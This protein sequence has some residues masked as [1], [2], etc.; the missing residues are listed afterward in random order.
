MCLATAEQRAAARAACL[1]VLCVPSCWSRWWLQ[2]LCNSTMHMDVRT[3]TPRT[4]V[5]AW[6]EMRGSIQLQPTPKLAHSTAGRTQGRGSIPLPAHRYLRPP[7]APPGP[8]TLACCLGHPE[9]QRLG[10]LRHQGHGQV[11]GVQQLV[12]QRLVAAG[13]VGGWRGEGGEVRLLL[14][15][16]QASLASCPGAGVQQQQ[17]QQQR[18][19]RSSGRASSCP[20]P[21][22]SAAHK[23]VA[24]HVMGEV[25]CVRSHCSIAL[26]S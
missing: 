5:H 21:G 1:S 12:L 25:S 23:G 8:T 15:V 19:R 2:W 20:K 22:A 18:R 14:C 13:G 4:D 16:Q 7:C 9:H 17:R 10:H 26:R 6:R 24:A 11:V 3:S